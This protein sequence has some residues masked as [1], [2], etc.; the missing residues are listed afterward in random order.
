MTT[1]YLLMLSLL[2]RNPPDLAVKNYFQRHGVICRSGDH[3][4]W[5]S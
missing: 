5:E 1:D 2:R 3:I 4:Y